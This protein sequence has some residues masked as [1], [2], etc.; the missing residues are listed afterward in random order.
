MM[1]TNTLKITLAEL[2]EKEMTNS[3]LN[4]QD[5]PGS[6]DGGPAN[7]LLI[8][9]PEDYTSSTLKIMFFGKE[10]NGY[11]GSFKD[12]KGVD[13]LMRVY[14]AFA[15]QSGAKKYGKHFWNAVRKF[16]AAFSK[17]NP[18]VTFTW[19]NIIKVGKDWSLGMPPESVMRWQENWF[20]VIRQEVQILK[21]DVV[22]FMCGPQYDK[23]IEK[24]FGS[25]AFVP[26]GNRP[27]R[28]LGRI[29]SGSLPPATFRTYHPNFLWRNG[30]Y[31]YLSEIVSEAESVFKK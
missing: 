20:Q 8:S 5:V 24:A 16:I 15:N 3:L 11:E 18:S 9:P 1:I 29:L 25:F 23:F 31:D 22:I 10:T 28:Q 30:F 12:S 7:P 13:H 19:N 2:Y 17:K 21:P 6:E 4:Y 27:E 14:D 26:V